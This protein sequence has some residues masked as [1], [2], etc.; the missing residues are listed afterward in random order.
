MKPPVGGG[1]Q[2][3]PVE[4]THLKD[5][6]R[7]EPPPSN[8]C[9]PGNQ[10]HDEISEAIKD[11]IQKRIN[12]RLPGAHDTILN[13]E[14]GTLDHP[15]RDRGVR[16]PGEVVKGRGHSSDGTTTEPENGWVIAAVFEYTCPAIYRAELLWLK[17][18]SNEYVPDFP[19]SLKRRNPVTGVPEYFSARETMKLWID[20]EAVRTRAPDS[21]GGPEA[22]ESGGGG[23]G[24]GDSENCYIVF[25]DTPSEGRITTNWRAIGFAW[26]NR[27]YPRACMRVK[28]INLP[29][30]H[31]GN[32]TGGGKIDHIT[33]VNKDYKYLQY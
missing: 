32:K 8:P 7:I 15:E 28:G 30:R 11:A 23:G 26:W 22:P 6:R 3:L 29:G 5:G 27:G 24:G 20:R 25:M 31:E 18:A 21:R 10:A 12:N 33:P 14:P 19:E 16:R 9:T 2:A 4:H 1:R 13:M 17:E